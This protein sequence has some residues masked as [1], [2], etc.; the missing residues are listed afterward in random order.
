MTT[1]SNTT[2][3]SSFLPGALVLALLV[4]GGCGGGD[5]EA[6]SASPVYLDGGTTDS[7]GGTL[8]GADDGTAP[9]ADRDNGDKLADASAPDLPRAGGEDDGLP[10]ADITDDAAPP[11]DIGDQGPPPV[12]T[13]DEGAPPADAPDHGAPPEDTADACGDDVCQ[14]G[15]H[16][17]CPGD[18]WTE[19]PS[20]PIVDTR[21]SACY[22]DSDRIACPAPGSAFAGQDAQYDGNLPSYRDN[23]DGTVSDLVTGL[24]WVKEHGDKA[25]WADAVAG[26]A[27]FELGGHDD[28][29]L[30]TIKELYSLIDFDGGSTQ[31]SSS[32]VP[33]IDTDYFT[34]RYGDEAQGERLIDAQY[35]SATEYVSTTMNGSHTVFGVNFADGRIKGYPGTNPGGRRTTQFVKYVRSG[36]GYGENDLVLDT[37]LIVEDRATGLIWQRG[38][39]GT[40]LG[41]EQ[42]LAYCE[43]LTLDGEDDW[44]LPNAKE[45][46][47]IVDYTRAPTVTSSAAIDPLFEVTE[48]ESYY[49]T[50]T[51]HLEGP[52]DR[53]GDAAVY[54]AFGRAMGFMEIPPGSGLEKI[55]V[56]GA[57]AQRSDPKTGNPADYPTGHGPQGDDIRI[58]NYAR[59]V[60]IGTHRHAGTLQSCGEGTCAGRETYRNCPRDCPDSGWTGNGGNGGTTDPPHGPTP[61]T[62]HTDCEAAG[63]CPPDAG[64]GCRCL[65]TR[66]GTLGCIPVCVTAADC[67]VIEGSTFQCNPQG[68]CVPE[69]P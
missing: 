41:W 1:T 28:W 64:A 52:P 56:H 12:D 51:S 21:Q 34:F 15:E 39:S 54:V 58:F 63:A 60:R 22:S 29:R 32:S 26:A 66:E 16:E 57:G 49:W 3:S 17:T 20:Y 35:W 25:A 27:T 61:C 30:P 42:A 14:P 8:P 11:T 53:A 55:D 38:D 45:L 9:V 23:G 4:S 33:Y 44:R 46:Q 65:M 59:C 68:V 40:A 18:C 10:P 50:S 69:R 47:S 6:A 36:A 5:P 2:T 43:D 7:G 19:Q 62:L 37:E 48:I 24:M 31:T 13:N 67:P